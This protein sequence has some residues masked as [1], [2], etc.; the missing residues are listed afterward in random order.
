M[1]ESETPRYAL[2]PVVVAADLAG[3]H[4]PAEGT[5]TLPQQLCWSKH[6]PEFD[7]SDEDQALELYETVF[8]SA[9]SAEDLAGY[10]NG[11]LL[12]QLWPE[13][14]IAP[15]VRRAWEAAHPLLALAPA[16]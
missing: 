2:R 13:L 7:L 14:D 8:D 12:A 3:L 4:G 1:A 16:A 6:T 11:R 15:R 9:R 5:V 10:V